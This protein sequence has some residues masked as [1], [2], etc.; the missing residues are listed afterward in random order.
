MRCV[1]EDCK[2]PGNGPSDGLRDAEDEADDRDENEFIAG[3]ARLHRLVLEVLVMLQW[4]SINISRVCIR[5]WLLKL[6]LER[7]FHGSIAV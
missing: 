6:Q 5:H 3:P 4:A 1:A 2:R 7:F